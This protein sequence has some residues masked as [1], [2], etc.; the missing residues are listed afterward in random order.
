MTMSPFWTAA[1]VGLGAGVLV[2]RRAH[3]APSSPV[4]ARRLPGTRLRTADLPVGGT[5]ALLAAGLLDRAGLHA[6]AVA[7]AGLALGA[8]VGAVGTGLAEPLP[9]AGHV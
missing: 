9:W 8:A 2:T 6:A 7:A 4:W 1:V 3:R 5:L